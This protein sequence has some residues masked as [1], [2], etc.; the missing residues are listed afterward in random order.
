MAI[1]CH[2]ERLNYRSL[3]AQCESGFMEGILEVYST[4]VGPARLGL[5]RFRGD[6]FE[7]IQRVNTFRQL[8]NLISNSIKYIA[9]KYHQLN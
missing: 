7:L 4:S 9:D 3:A 5:V 6:W 1:V 8:V 2:D